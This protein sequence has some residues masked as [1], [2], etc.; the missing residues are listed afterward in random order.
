[1]NTQNAKHH[2]LDLVRRRLGPHYIVESWHSNGDSWIQTKPESLLSLLSFLKEDPDADLQRLVDVSCIDH[3][4][5]NRPSAERFELIYLLSSIRLKYRIGLSVPI[6]EDDPLIPSVTG[7]YPAADWLER[8]LWESFG[9]QA[10]GHPNLRRLLLYPGFEGYPFRQDYPLTKKQP[11]I[12][13]RQSSRA[14]TVVDS[15]QPKGI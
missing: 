12:P 7:I 5:S 4:G 1:M 9:I 8:E 10:V 6:S 3:I 14:P 15:S 13:L 11:L 2:L